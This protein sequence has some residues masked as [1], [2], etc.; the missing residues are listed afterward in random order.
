[1]V[2][3][4]FIKVTAADNTP[5]NPFTGSHEAGHILFN[6]GEERQDTTNLMYF[7]TSPLDGIQGTKRI[8]RSQ[9]SNS[10]NTSQTDMLLK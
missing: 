4:S 3:T 9:H 7:T 5:N 10:R 6:S 8:T 2:N 1:M